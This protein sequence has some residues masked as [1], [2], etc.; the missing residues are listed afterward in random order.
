M[1]AT[2]KYEKA[3]YDKVLVRLPK[4]TKDKIREYNESVN[5]F[6]VDAVREKLKLEQ[7]KQ[8]LERLINSP[9]DLPFL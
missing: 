7:S 3:N 9:E 6:I 8:E 4:G 5:G 1:R 2:A